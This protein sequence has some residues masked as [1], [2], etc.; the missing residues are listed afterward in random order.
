MTDDGVARSS[1]LMAS[2]TLVSRVL[3]LIRA[4]QLAAVIGL[5]GLSADAF[6]VANT[7]PNNFYL[8]LAGGILNAVLVPQIVR[9]TSHAD[10]GHDFVNRLLT[11]SLVLMGAATLGATALAPLWVWIFSDTQ[12]PQAR[13]L[14]VAFAFICLPQI[15]FYGLYTL[16]GQVLNARGHFAAY[17]WAPVVANLVSLAG[18]LA[19]RFSSLPLE[20]APGQWTPAM[21]WLLAGTATVSILAQAVSLIPPLRRAGFRFRPTWG[22]R[23]VG[24]GTASRVAIW[25]FAAVALSQAGFAVTSRVLTRATRLADD[26]GVVAAGKNSYDNAF[27][28]FMLPHSLITVSLATALFTRMATAAHSGDRKA[29]VHDLGRGLRLPAPILVPVGLAGF[30]FAPLVTAVFFTTSSAA[31]TDAVAGVLSTML[32]GVAPFGWLYLIN[33]VYYAYE[34]ARTPFY[35]QVVVT[36]SATAVNLFAATLP[37]DRTGIWVGVGQTLSN[38]LAAGI[39]FVLL[40]RRLGRLGLGVTV[41]T[42]V[43]LVVASAAAGAIAVG[44]LHLVSD[45]IE[46]SRLMSL[47]ALAGFG[48]AYVL[49]T[50]AIAHRMRVREVEELL[51]PVLRRLPGAGRA[52]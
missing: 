37:V 17:M 36:G 8:L 46:G 9:S 18:L 3:G 35:L 1:A 50:W 51:A 30:A 20:A 26:L 42:Y 32:V 44:G 4:S 48:M 29:V 23:G 28:L 40:R 49:L 24:L 14:A 10:G 21:I 5:T 39:G 25:T 6:S 2:G 33:R 41:R 11:L 15:F 45:R 38:V 31:Q 52:R 27:L 16:L 12:N 47:A 7:L 22:F 34:D 19:F 43:R 13:A